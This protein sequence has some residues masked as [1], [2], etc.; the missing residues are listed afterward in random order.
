MGFS[1]GAPD[2]LS[3]I[4]REKRADLEAEKRAVPIE[5]LVDRAKAHESRGFLGALSGS[6][7]ALIAEIKKASPSAGILRRDYDP[8]ALAGSYERGGAAAISV[9][10]EGRHF[11]GHLSH[12]TLVRGAVS[13]PVL[14]KDFILDEYGVFESASA[15]ADAVLL[16]ARILEARELTRLVALCHE[17]RIEPLVEVFDEEDIGKACG[18]A[19]RIVGINN[20]DLRSLRVSIERSMK[21]K[22]LVP[23]DRLIVSESGIWSREDI[24]ALE[25]AGIRAALVGESLLRHADPGS[26][27]AALLAR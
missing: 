23:A 26:A 10:T 11:G 3:E 7:F 8:A 18:T 4:V 22:R 17:L 12:L 24:I 21:L 13:L 27:L 19:A 5:S 2:I 16:I 25:R 15:G 6:G 14:R 1:D 20:R 9:L